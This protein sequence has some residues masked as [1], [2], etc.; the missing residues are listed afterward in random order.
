MAFILH[1]KQARHTQ[2]NINSI[3]TLIACEYITFD[4]LIKPPMY[5]GM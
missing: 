3:W 5:A 4:A 2:H 1:I